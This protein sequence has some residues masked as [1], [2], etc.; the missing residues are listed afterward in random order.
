MKRPTLFNLERCQAL[1]RE[2]G[3]DLL[4]PSTDAH[5]Y[6]TA[7]FPVFEFI[8]EPE[9]VAFSLIPADPAI[10]PYLIIPHCN[11]MSLLQFP[12]WIPRTGFFGQYY[13][14]DAPEI[15]GFRVDSVYEAVARALAEMGLT[16]ARVGIEYDR[17]SVGACERL[18]AALPRV[19]FVDGTDVLL[20][21][22]EIK[23]PEEIARLKKAGD[24]IE[25]GIAACY[26]AARP[27]M[28]ELDLERIIRRTVLEEGC[29]T[30]YVQVGT[31]TRGAI[32]PLFSSD[33]P[34][35]EGDLIRID[36]SARYQRYVSDICRMAVVGEPTRQMREVYAAVFE[37]EMAAINLVKPGVKISELFE[38]AVQVPPT[39]GIADYRRH[40]VG[41]GLGISS[42]ER[43]FLTPRN[44]DVLQEGMVL[45]VETPY[46]L[47]GVG[48]FAPEDQV[49][50]T[51]NGFE[52][53]TTPQQELIRI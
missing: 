10:E 12:T 50:V 49:I 8:C 21:T 3:L 30:N 35:Q 39:R 42:H 41:H 38:A 43:P 51:E 16:R 37:A 5:I 1:M 31:G 52:L 2:Q 36:A 33:T 13:I 19:E 48:G 32:G 53:M 20:A 44:H 45:C 25:K 22:R 40:H 4:A 28:T 23:T 27:G 47:W 9:T 7:E 17:L 26:A 15:P 18:K 11:R 14:T 46:Y 6:Y 24:A 34:I 29:T